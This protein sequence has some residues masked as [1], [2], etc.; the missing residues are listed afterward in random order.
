MWRGAKER[1]GR[2]KGTRKGRKES[3]VEKT[4]RE[5]NEGR[6]RKGNEKKRRGSLFSNFWKNGEVNEE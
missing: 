4:S 1:G 5:T 6:K 2:I 3:S